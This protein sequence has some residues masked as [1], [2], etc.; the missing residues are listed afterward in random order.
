MFLGCLQQKLELLT[1]RDA[2][3]RDLSLEELALKAKLH[4][5]LF[6][7]SA[8]LIHRTLDHPWQESVDEQGDDGKDSNRADITSVT[9][10]ASH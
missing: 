9:H 4:G 10:K 3:G 6:H 2:L 5:E 1:A 7:G 8:V